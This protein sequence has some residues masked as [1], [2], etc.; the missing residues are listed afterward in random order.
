MEIQVLLFAQLAAKIGHAHLKLQVPNDADVATAL[1]RLTEEFPVIQGDLPH[2]AC[3]L[4]QRYVALDTRL[5][6]GCELALIPP[7]SGG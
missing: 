3:A 6:P 2:V 4:A 7:V 1:R 5:H